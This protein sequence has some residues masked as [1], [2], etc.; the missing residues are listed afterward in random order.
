LAWAYAQNAD[1]YFEQID[2][3]EGFSPSMISSIVQEQ[4]G[5]I[6][7]GTEN[8]LLRYDG[9]DFIHYTRDQNISGGISNNRINV[10]F[11]DSRG[12]LWIGTS[13]GVNHFNKDTKIFSP[14]DILPIKGGRNYITSI[15]EDDQ[16]NLWVAT[17][18]GVKK[19]NRAKSLLENVAKESNSELFTTDRVLSLLFDPDL[20]IL[21]G[22]S[23][24]IKCFDPATGIQRELPKAFQA[25]ATFLKDKMWRM[26]RDQQGDLWFAT[27]SHGGYH[28]NKQTGTL[29]NY[30]HDPQRRTSIASNWVYDIL[31]VDDHTMWF[32]TI[33]GVS[34]L[35]HKTGTF[36]SHVHNP[37][38]LYSLSD[39]EIRC[40]L[41]DHSGSIWIGTE[42][43]GLNFFNQANNNFVKVG[44]SIA[45]NFG[46]TNPVV[47]AVLNDGESALWVGTNGGGL[48]YLDF[49]HRSS[50]SYQIQASDQMKTRNMINALADYDRET[51]LCGT[52]YGLYRFNKKRASFEMLSLSQNESARE[53]P[54][55]ALMV[56]GT[57]IW[58]GTEGDGLKLVEQGKVTSFSVNSS[59]SSISD[60]YITDIEKTTN[61][62]WIATQDGLNFFDKSLGRITAVYRS[63]GP[64]ALSNNNLTT[65]FLDAHRR[66]WI[67]TDFGGLNYFDE[68][69]QQFYLLNQAR[70]L[71]DNSIK[72]IAEDSQGHLWISSDGRLF[73]LNLH[74]GEEDFDPAQ[75][76]ITAYSSNDG[77][78]FGQF[79][80]N[81]A[82]ELSQNQLAFGTS[83]GLV[84]FSATGIIKS[85]NNSDVIFTKLKIHNKEVSVQDEG[86]P[87][88]QDIA[89]TEGIELDYDQGYLEIE[90]SAMNFVNADNNRY[91]YKLE[92]AYRKDD[93]HI[94]GSQNRVSLT[95]LNHGTYVFSVKTTSEDQV[96]ENP[97]SAIRIVI[98]PPWWESWWAYLLYGLFMATIAL[99]IIRIINIRIR[100][101]RALFIEHVER[102]RQEELYK[103]KLDFFTNVSHEIR[104]PLSLM[105]APLEDLLD[106]VDKDTKVERRLKTIKNNSD[107]LLKLVNELL[108]FRKAENGL[109]KI[110]CEEHDLISFC[111]EIYESFKEL[112]VDKNITY[113][114]AIDSNYLPVY[115]DRYQMEKVLYNLL[116]NAF[117]FTKD[118]G[119]IVLAVEG[120]SQRKGWVVIKVK[121]DGIGISEQNKKN[122]FQRFFQ[123]EDPNVQQAGT[124]VGL[125]LSKSIIELHQ[126]EI[127]VA[128]EK[129]PWATTVF[130]ISLRL[131]SKHLPESQVVFSPMAREGQFLEVKEVEPLPQLD[132][133]PLIPQADD[134]DRKRLLIVEDNVEFRAFLKDI[135]QD[136]YQIIDF[137]SGKDAIQY[138]EEE[139]PDLIVSDVMM[140]EMSGLELCEWVKTNESTNHVPVILLTAKS[141]T[142]SRIEG[143]TNGA[144]SYITKPF[145][146]KVLKLNIT[147]LLVAKEI[148]RHKYSGS[149]I[150][151]AELKQLTTPEEVFIKKL[152]EI[153]ESN[154]EDPEFSVNDL[155]K[156]IGMS[157]TI[158]YK[159]VNMLTNHSIA[160]LI[161]H[162]R[163]KKAADILLQTSYS[164]SEVAYMVGFNDRK[165]FSRE[166][167]KVYQSSPT[168][169]KSSSSVAE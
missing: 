136:E 107:R 152:M 119:R 154:L 10:V 137:G 53:Y 29:T 45:P 130:Q 108:D 33:D 117:K 158:L 133:L 150:I 31:E 149:F 26:L 82:L 124:G 83:K 88:S 15:I 92:S 57:D 69:T 56:D 7:I 12:E 147:N 120:E 4:K 153:I 67:G 145:S 30:Q 38:N 54:I 76:E 84:R 151:D 114:F 99:V 79:S 140:P 115:F 48:N 68:K 162:V 118:H 97:A 89:D 156:Q 74:A 111:F 143:L 34:V 47:N 27:K 155:V 121:D 163:L 35:N 28:Y 93:W 127:G 144:D 63:G 148:L 3:A 91:A 116:S 90:F 126:G 125:A 20:G 139:I 146:I 66:L 138:M 109:M 17:F 58:V 110:A 128:E 104:T 165:H 46:L 164:V 55:T 105:T 81:C 61:G 60:N 100:L 19:L 70:G 64:Q 23:D 101:K 51:L 8:G 11:E 123:I 122:I 113:K 87:L 13:N 65:L 42:V 166:F 36:A 167:K 37:Y 49:T 73:E 32:A 59:S 168:E 77:L 96:W 134:H 132:T 131:G 43:G 39:N 102:E 22:A 78:S 2:Y 85:A 95:D 72:S 80:H 159:K 135:L 6:W 160:T 62:I 44:E 106:L 9:Y 75:V 40:F 14:I 41:K 24:G 169:Y 94:I 71:T 98:R 103:M 142:D 52:A 16:G 141:S 50:T 161:K 5:F 129:D 1:L 18:G 112:S 25:N 157:R 21:V 86:S